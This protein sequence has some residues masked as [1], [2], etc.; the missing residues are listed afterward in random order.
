MKIYFIRHGQ[1][2]Y[3]V[4]KRIQ[5]YSVDSPLT[6]QGIQSA[7]QVG[8]H[9][10]D[11]SFQSVY[12]SPQK[13]AVDTCRYILDQNHHLVPEIQT[14]ERLREMN[15]G[16]YDGQAIESFRQDGYYD[17]FTR[18]PNGFSALQ[19]G[20]EDYMTLTK[21]GI[22]FLTDIIQQSDEKDSILVVAHS[23]MLTVLL[24]YLAGRRISDCRRQGILDNT[25]I[26]CLNWQD[27]FYHMECYNFVSK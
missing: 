18:C 27:N 9:L 19:T 4:A 1:T 11:I 3:N 24:Q 5:G 7:K 6:E 26:S 14:D 16:C 21:R 12:A 22:S 2:E 17:V 25:S 13:R 10:S 20:G 23:L 15:F 8:C